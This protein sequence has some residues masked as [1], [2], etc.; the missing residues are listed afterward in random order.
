[1]DWRRRWRLCSILRQHQSSAAV[2]RCLTNGFEPAQ[3]VHVNE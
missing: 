1:V 3:V 2:S